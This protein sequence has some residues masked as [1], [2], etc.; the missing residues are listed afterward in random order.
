M[1]M[2]AHTKSQTLKMPPPIK[3]RTAALQI[4][5]EDMPRGIEVGATYRASLVSQVLT[6]YTGS[7]LQLE[8]IPHT[9]ND[10]LGGGHDGNKVVRLGVGVEVHIVLLHS[11]T[12]CC[13]NALV[14]SRI[15]DHDGA[16][17]NVAGVDDA[18]GPGR[19]SRANSK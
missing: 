13:H 15:I 9:C 17:N 3:H 12:N 10:L 8:L 18:P 14:A 7:Q 19:K 5:T 2:I 16:A 1:G 11:M 6:R 4:D